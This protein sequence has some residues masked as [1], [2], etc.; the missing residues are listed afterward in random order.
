MRRPTAPERVVASYEEL[1]ALLSAEYG[2]PVDVGHEVPFVHQDNRGH[3][4]NGVMD[5]LWETAEGTVIVD[6]KT[7]GGNKAEALKESIQ[8]HAS[9]MHEYREALTAARKK[10]L[11]TVL[12]YPVTGV[13]I[14]VKD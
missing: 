9:Q 12:Y 4:Y 13:L 3:V 8:K 5:L 14:E 11:A 2:K 10:V 1:C 6:F 7:F